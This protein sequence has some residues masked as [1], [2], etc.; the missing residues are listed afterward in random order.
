MYLTDGGAPPPA[1]LQFT[2]ANPDYVLDT[3]EFPVF[4]T[5]GAVL[6]TT[7]MPYWEI[8]PNPD[9]RLSNGQFPSN[10]I[11]FGGS[12][13]SN[14]QAAPVENTLVSH[15]GPGEGRTSAGVFVKVDIPEWIQSHSSM[16]IIRELQNKFREQ[17]PQ[18]KQNDLFNGSQ[19][20]PFPFCG[21]DG[22]SGIGLSLFVAFELL[23]LV[24]IVAANVAIISVIRDMNKSTK[25]RQYRSNN[26]F[27]LSLAVAD[28]CLGLSILPAGI[29]SSI[30]ALI[31][32]N[33]NVGSVQINSLGS[34]PA[35]IFGSG[36]V[37][38][39]I[40]G[41]WSILLVQIDLFL[42]IR[43]PME[44]HCGSLLTTKRA[45]IVT[46]F[47][48]CL[49][50]GIVVALWPLGFSFAIQ[51]ATLTYSP[52]LLPKVE[53]GSLVTN[54]DDMFKIPLYACIVWGVPFLLTLPLGAYLVHAIGK[55]CKKLRMRTQASY[56][57]RHPEHAQHRSRVRKDWEA[58]CRIMIVELVYVVTFLPTIIAHIV[59]WKH[60]GCD[61][62]ANVFHFIGQFT[63]IV[64]SF[65]NLFIYHLM[66]KDFQTRMRTLFC[67]QPASPAPYERKTGFTSHTT[68]TTA[69][70]STI[71]EVNY[72]IRVISLTL[73]NPVKK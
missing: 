61:P 25:N 41:I 67:G 2:T 26:V 43:W 58:V 18:L 24:L 21:E 49:A 3:T 27:K 30:S 55:A 28:L 6:A 47:I 44:Q 45:R 60:D 40:V 54:S 65:V 42:R 34:I 19:C 63:L 59:Y 14:R 72:P 31:D 73:D 32:Q 16:D 52:I 48:W 22:C 56:I 36:A 9:E 69:E 46:V 7:D 37:I 53:N 50:V 20:H 29:Q 62:R 5:T 35:I 68:V 15:S 13:E 33:F 4:D 70:I 1:F 51:P 66:W 23:L 39:T 11:N 57:K 8:T 12:F 38:A 17:I 64:G 71:S 10:L